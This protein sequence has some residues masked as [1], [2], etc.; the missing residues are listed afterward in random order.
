MFVWCF[1]VARIVSYHAGCRHKLIAWTAQGMEKCGRGLQLNHFMPTTPRD[2]VPNSPWLPCSHLPSPPS[3]ML[4][5]CQLS[6]RKSRGTT[7]LSRAAFLYVLFV[8][9]VL[10]R[11]WEDLQLLR[12][13]AW[14]RDNGVGRV[15]GRVVF[16]ALPHSVPIIGFR[17]RVWGRKEGLTDTGQFPEKLCSLYQEIRTGRPGRVPYTFTPK[18]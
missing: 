17:L 6:I 14:S 11:I 5:T 13:S 2:S 3:P 8:E 12:G 9:H 18:A 10:I 15:Y 16:R 1:P 4:L 7:A